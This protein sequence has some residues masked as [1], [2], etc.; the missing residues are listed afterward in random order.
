MGDFNIDMDKPDSPVYAELNDFCD[1][2]GLANMIN[3]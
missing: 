2:F 3:K 1:I